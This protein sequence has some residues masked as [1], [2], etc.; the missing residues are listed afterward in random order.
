MMLQRTSL[1]ASAKWGAQSLAIFLWG[2]VEWGEGGR[3]P[4]SCS[5]EEAGA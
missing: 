4:G 3:N 2:E 5:L 1:G